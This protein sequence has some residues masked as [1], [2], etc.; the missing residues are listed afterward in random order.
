MQ[1]LHLIH[2]ANTGEGVPGTSQLIHWSHQR[3][4][5]PCSFIS[6]KSLC[7]V[8]PHWLSKQPPW[9]SMWTHYW[10]S[11]SLKTEL[12]GWKAQI[13]RQNHQREQPPAQHHLKPWW[14][15]GSQCESE[16]CEKHWSWVQSKLGVSRRLKDVGTTTVTVTPCVD[17]SKNEP[18][19]NWKFVVT[20]YW[21]LGGE[22]CIPWKQHFLSTCS[23]W[24]LGWRTCK[25]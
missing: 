12:L 4:I 10:Y 22:L 24:V 20:S 1:D 16:W 9:E 18:G 15:G 8:H 11:N 14:P 23:C 7:P 13:T 21:E 19:R 2:Q 6:P 5:R 3:S 25:G 17:K